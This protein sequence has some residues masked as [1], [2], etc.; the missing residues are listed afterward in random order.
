MIN[1]SNGVGTDTLTIMDPNNSTDIVKQDGSAFTSSPEGTFSHEALDHGH[2][3]GQGNFN[4]STGEQEAVETADT[5][6][7]NNDEEQRETY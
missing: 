2:K 3:K 5:Y 6:R 7:A 1:E 4:R